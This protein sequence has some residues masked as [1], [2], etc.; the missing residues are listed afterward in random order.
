MGPR[1]VAGNT[2][3]AVT[4]VSVYHHECIRTL[5]TRYVWIPLIQAESV[6]RRNC[7]CNCIAGLR[8]LETL[9]VNGIPQVV[10]QSSN[11]RRRASSSP[12][13]RPLAPTSLSCSRLPPP[14]ASPMPRTAGSSEQVRLE[15]PCLSRSAAGRATF[16]FGKIPILGG[17][18]HGADEFG[19]GVTLACVG[20]WARTL[21]QHG[22]SRPSYMPAENSSDGWARIACSSPRAPNS[23]GLGRGLT[24]EFG[25]CRVL[26]IH[27]CPG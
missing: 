15:E 20:G 3:D 11:L 8:P 16:P 25:G 17:I 12:R 1:V 9:K 5:D 2:W 23:D 6:P 7:R 19:R 18:G 26:Q 4:W 24:L 22:N 13:G 27:F 10:P 21:R 14:P